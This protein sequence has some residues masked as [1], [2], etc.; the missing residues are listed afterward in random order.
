MLE[1]FFIIFAGLFFLI[2]TIVALFS[3]ISDRIK[4][5][6][7]QLQSQVENFQQKVEELEEEL[8]Q[9]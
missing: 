3:I 8:K 4:K 7:N 6:T 2:I 5:P 1:L 9:K